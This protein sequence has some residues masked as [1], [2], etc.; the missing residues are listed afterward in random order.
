MLNRSTTSYVQERASIL[1]PHT[2]MQRKRNSL[3]LIAFQCA[4]QSEDL[5]CDGPYQFSK[6]QLVF[7]LL[8]HSRALL[9]IPETLARTRGQK[10][11][12]VYTGKAGLVTTV[13]SNAEAAFR[14]QCR[15]VQAMDHYMKPSPYKVPLFIGFVDGDVVL[16]FSLKELNAV[17]EN[18]REFIIQR[19]V[20]SSQGRAGKVRVTW[21]AKQRLTYSRLRRKTSYPFNVSGIKT[22][23]KSRIRSGSLYIEEDTGTLKSS[24]TQQLRFPVLYPVSSAPAPTKSMSSSFA[25]LVAALSP[26]GDPYTVCFSLPGDTVEDL[27][28]KPGLEPFAL[29]VVSA[30]QTLK[31]LESQEVTHLK[32]DLL[33]G[34]DGLWYFLD[35]KVLRAESV[36]RRVQQRLDTLG[37]QTESMESGTKPLSR[38]LAKL[39]S[40]FLSDQPLSQHKPP[41]IPRAPSHFSSFHT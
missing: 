11:V 2:N 34:A 32:F 31:S 17:I 27:C 21:E 22:K 40:F 25:N 16:V 1:F 36:E 39:Q 4:D 30:V 15:S 7:S 12:F 41:Y 37:Y 23:P 35:V 28:L 19:Y 5:D 33:E 14:A 29:E 13:E 8:R 9:R 6:S 20:A 3:S 18:E 24:T 10:A 38:T 26:V